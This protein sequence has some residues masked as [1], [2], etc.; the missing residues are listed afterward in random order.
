MKNE[1][2]PIKYGLIAGTFLPI[3]LLSAIFI[4][5]PQPSS[6]VIMTALMDLY[7]KYGY[8]IIFLGAF[9][10]SIL[11]I[12]LY[13]PGSTAV[14]LGAILA[15]KGELSLALVIFAGATGALLAYTADYY[16][17]K[18]GWYKLLVR[19]GLSNYLDKAKKKMD[20]KNKKKLIF[21][22]CI[23]P[24]YAAILS[25]AAGILSLN[26]REFFI[27]FILAQFFWSTFWGVLFYNF[28][29]N[30]LDFVVKYA[31]YSL[32]LFIFYWT[33]KRTLVLTK[34]GIA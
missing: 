2:T 24:N 11:L 5:L 18:Y 7:L 17:G 16:M 4:F 28:G 6:E 23:H 12:N 22:G 32:F 19:F 21:V 29:Y 31:S 1:G 3:I 15:S 30:V 9:I 26:I 34:K 13:I 33:I 27:Y 10:E 8:L 14:L 20:G 25:T